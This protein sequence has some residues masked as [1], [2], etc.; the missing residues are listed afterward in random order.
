[1]RVSAAVSYLRLLSALVTRA[2]SNSEAN[3]RA[4][5]FIPALLKAVATQA[6]ILRGE[7]TV[8]T[9]SA[10][11]LT[12]GTGVSGGSGGGTTRGQGNGGVKTRSA[13]SDSVVLCM[14]TLRFL[15][16]WSE[17]PISGSSSSGGNAGPP[18]KSALPPGAFP[19][20]TASDAKKS[21][22]GAPA[23]AS[24]QSSV[25]GR[26]PTASGSGAP[27]SGTSSNVAVGRPVS[28]HGYQARRSFGAGASGS[29]DV[30]V[31]SPSHVY[32]LRGD[33][34]DFVEPIRQPVR[35]SN[36]RSLW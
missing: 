2:P 8:L 13:A 23:P 31:L 29:G 35:R 28:H 21:T 3:A 22:M 27:G 10:S 9:P 17:Q 32:P 30:P 33:S 19:G 6:S 25:A 5:V 24:T 20:D 18:G 12:T 1:M 11:G 15:L 26:P 36:A 16:T 34:C 14:Q 7:D 4:R